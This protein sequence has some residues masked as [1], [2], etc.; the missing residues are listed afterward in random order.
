MYETDLVFSCGEE[1]FLP[2]VDVWIVIDVLR[3][4]TVMTRWFELGG[5]E[6]YP[7]KT[8]DD[9]RKLVLELRD[10]GSSPLLMGEINA[11]PP[12]GFDLGNSPTQLN[13]E[14]VQAHYCGVMSTTNGTVA[15]NEAFMSGSPV[16]ASSFRNY[17]ACLDHALT[18]GNKI[19]LLC[20]GRK[21][22]PSWE[23]TLCAGAIIDRLNSLGYVQM[24]DSSRIALNLWKNRDKNN[25]ADFVKQSEH[26]KYL[27]KIGFDDDI[28]FACECDSSTVVPMLE[29]NNSHII[30]QSVSGSARPYKTFNALSFHDISPK[31]EPTSPKDPFEELLEYTKERRNL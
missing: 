1:N 11:L 7:V 24:S 30:L 12:E 26:A 19:G 2:V 31:E 14:I 3:A 6:L 21:K 17:S 28:K 23:D 16:I 22:R 25:L 15:L 9:A 18:L 4:T 29:K 8:P 27:E 10:R 13:Y 20:S 5:T